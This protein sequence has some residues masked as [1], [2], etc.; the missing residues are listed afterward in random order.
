VVFTASEAGQISGTLEDQRH[1]VFTYYFLKGLNGA[2]YAAN[3]EGHVTA[4]SLF[5]YLA[6]LVNA[7]AHRHS[8]DQRPQLLP[9]PDK[10]A[11]VELR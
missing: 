5:T 2:A 1:G 4:G 9:S 11:D 8:R 7:A 3:R 6:P 10:S